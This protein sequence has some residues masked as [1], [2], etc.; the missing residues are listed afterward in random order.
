MTKENN[1]MQVDIDTLKKQNVNDLLSI[2]E[3]YRNLKETEEKISQIKYIDNTLVKKLKKEYERLK[4]INFDVDLQIKLTNDIETINSKL[5]T[6]AKQIDLDNERKRI[7][8]IEYITINTPMETD[9]YINYNHGN[10][11]SH[12]AYKCSDYINVSS[13]KGKE[14]NVTTY[15]DYSSGIAQY[16][17]D[18]SFISGIGQGDYKIGDNQ[19]IKIVGDYIRVTCKTS[20]INDFKMFIRLNDLLKE[21]NEESSINPCEYNGRSMTMFNKGICIGDSFTEGASNINASNEQ[22]ITDRFNYP[23]ILSK[24]SNVE[25]INKGHSGITSK[26]WF[27]KYKNTDLS[28][29]DF[30]IIYLGINDYFSNNKTLFSNEYGQIIDKLRNENEHIKI[31]CVTQTRHFRDFAN[32][33][34][35]VREI[36]TEKDCYLIDLEKYSTFSTKHMTGAHP[37]AYG[38]F[39][40]A[41]DIY[42]YISYIIDN[43]IDDFKNHQFTNTDYSY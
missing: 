4:E 37:N 39:T 19:K 17:K 41:N 18:K 5:D 26:G 9:G 8:N 33:T 11:V 22:F 12:T 6:K 42:S 35:Y 34:H 13:Y 23:K 14:I 3:L 1:K 25:I 7:D 24:L 43:N 10:F 30:A 2:K 21:T 27:E 15:F 31:F 20:N 28:G 38:Y 36:A 16:Q 32:F 40:M 29:Y